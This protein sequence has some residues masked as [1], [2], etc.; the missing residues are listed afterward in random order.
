MIEEMWPGKVQPITSSP[1][2]NIDLKSDN[3]KMIQLSC[4]TIGASIEY[5]ILGKN[6]FVF[7]N[8]SFCLS[9]V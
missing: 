4:T 7:L 6:N 2:I 5:P 9:M 8:N 3:K 1:E